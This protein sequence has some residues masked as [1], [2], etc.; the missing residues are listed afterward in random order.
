[1][2][3]ADLQK[4]RVAP[5]KLVPKFRPDVLQYSITVASSVAEVKLTPLTSDT[6]ASC[7][8]KVSLIQGRLGHAAILFLCPQGDAAAGRT[9][10][11]IEGRTAVVEVVVTAEDGKTCKNYVVS[12][13]RLSADDACLSSLDVSAG[14]LRP[15]FSP[16]CTTI[17]AY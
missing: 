11:L 2:D 15:C 4:L 1:M 10:K 14:T 17:T 6:G 7:T 9:V 3:N 16:A 8:V 12:I 5:G 13:R